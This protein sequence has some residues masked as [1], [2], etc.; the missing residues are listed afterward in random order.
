MH[1]G[2]SC[3]PADAVMLG[4]SWAVDVLG[5]CAAGVAAVWLNR[6]G[7]ACPDPA[8]ARELRTLQPVDHVAALLL[9]G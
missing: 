2:E 9:G 6:H 4:D 1:A 5:V 3:A 8:L 7:R